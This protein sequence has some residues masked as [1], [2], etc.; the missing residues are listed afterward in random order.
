M[1]KSNKERA[2]LK[3]NGYVYDRRLQRWIHHEERDEYYRQEQES[4]LIALWILRIFVGLVL[5]WMFIMALSQ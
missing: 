4:T 2:E 1:A 5:F 3:K